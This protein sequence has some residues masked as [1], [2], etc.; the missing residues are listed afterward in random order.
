MIKK[1]VQKMLNLFSKMIPIRK[2]I[3]LESNPD[4][5]DNTVVLFDEMLQDDKLMDY[6]FVWIVKNNSIPE[7]YLNKSNIT[8][9]QLNKS[10]FYNKVKNKIQLLYLFASASYV[11]FSHIL[12]S[13]FEP[14][15]GQEVIFLTHGFH[16]KKGNGRH[17]N[18]KKVTKVLT[19]SDL[20]NEVA[21]RTYDVKGHKLVQLGYS[22]N[23][24]LFKQGGEIDKFLPKEVLNKE[25]IVWLPTFRRHSN[26]KT[27]DSKKRETESDL[28]LINSTDDLQALNSIVEKNNMLLIIKPHPAQNMDYFKINSLS[29]ILVITNQELASYNCHL[30]DLLAVSSCLITDYS[31]VFIDY[32]LLNKPIIFTSDDIDNY[33]DN[34]GFTL[35]GYQ[36]YMPGIMVE[37]ASELFDTLETKSYESESFREMRIK[38]KNEVHKNING[39]Y[40]NGIINNFFA[41]KE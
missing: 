13:P 11:F 29:S 3:I 23:D 31:S 2:T 1:T 37:I 40:S 39:Q 10:G 14:K 27:N 41:R 9:F 6:K 12:Y 36:D 30:Y 38:V 5:S 18:P 20:D 16:F 21:K 24:L 28:P 8:F 17:F 25:I 15:N 26:G 32:L 35:E 4:F 7:K 22:R 19:L 34:L 33:N